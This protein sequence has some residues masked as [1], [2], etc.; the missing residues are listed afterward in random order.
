MIFIRRDKIQ[1]FWRPFIK[2]LPLRSVLIKSNICLGLCTYA[3]R[4]LHIGSASCLNLETAREEQTVN[5]F[6]PACDGTVGVKHR[7][8]RLLTE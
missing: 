2:A 6:Y 7:V 1:I 4:Y 8:G 5:T 3:G